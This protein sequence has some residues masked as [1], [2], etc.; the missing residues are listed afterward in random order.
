MN[1][2]SKLP[3]ALNKVDAEAVFLPV[4]FTEDRDR[5]ELTGSSASPMYAQAALGHFQAIER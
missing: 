3:S 4:G 2:A 5:R 1:P